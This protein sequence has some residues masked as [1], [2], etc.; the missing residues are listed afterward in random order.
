MHTQASPYMKSLAAIQ[1]QLKGRVLE[2]STAK[3]ESVRVPGHV[4]FLIALLF[5]SCPPFSPMQWWL[6][7]GPHV[8][9]ACSAGRV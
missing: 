1:E 5:D 7:K 6:N 9:L 2:Q 8:Y 3:R 4:Y